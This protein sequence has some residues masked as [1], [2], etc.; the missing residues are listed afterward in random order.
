MNVQEFDL[1]DG[2]TTLVVATSG[3]VIPNVS[4]VGSIEVPR[5]T[6]FKAVYIEGSRKSW[7]TAFVPGLD[8][9]SLT[10]LAKEAIDN[11]LTATA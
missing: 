5:G 1:M 8:N 2:T 9:D 11:Y 3:D 6:F 7:R 10:A 4:E